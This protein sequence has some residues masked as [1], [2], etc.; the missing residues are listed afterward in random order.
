MTDTGQDARDA[1]DAYK[2]SISSLEDDMKAKND[3][4]KQKMQ[5]RLAARKKREAGSSWADCK[6]NAQ[7]RRLQ[8]GMKY[9]S[10]TSPVPLCHCSSH[11]L[12]LSVLLAPLL[13]SYCTCRMSWLS[14]TLCSELAQSIP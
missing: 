8:R 1:L 12:P 11:C 7:E 14:T 5:D 3:A 13:L 2:K 4:A 6:V 10:R 9:V